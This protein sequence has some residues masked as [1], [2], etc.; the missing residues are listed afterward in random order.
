[1]AQLFALKTNSKPH[2]VVL[3]DADCIESMLRSVSWRFEFFGVK[4]QTCINSDKG[5]V[6]MQFEAW[7]W[8]ILKT[9]R[10]IDDF[11]RFQMYGKSSVNESSYF[12]LEIEVEALCLLEEALTYQIRRD[13]DAFI[14]SGNK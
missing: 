4:P 14:E 9:K 7:E 1:M 13:C 10:F 3:M 2:M 11:S 8:E 6:C 5:T 12:Y